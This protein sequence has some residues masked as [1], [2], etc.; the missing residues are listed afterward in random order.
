M[1]LPQIPTVAEIEAMTTKEKMELAKASLSEMKQILGE[2]CIEFL[3]EPSFHA[4]MEIS[5]MM[6]DYLKCFQLDVFLTCEMENQ[7]E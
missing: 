6:A 7:E 3:D 2:T 1:E 4:G 5:G